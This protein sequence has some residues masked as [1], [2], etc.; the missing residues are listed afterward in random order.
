MDSIGNLLQNKE[1]EENNT[2]GGVNSARGEAC[3][4]LCI[5]LDQDI[6]ESFMYWM[7]KTKRKGMEPSDIHDMIKKCKREGDN[8]QALF[9]WL[10]KRK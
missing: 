3:E 2:K 7:G 4:K 5:F 8:P 10:F 1:L 9:M 6:D